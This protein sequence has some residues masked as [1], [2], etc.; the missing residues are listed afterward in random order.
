MHISENGGGWGVGVKG[1][2][3]EGEKK[4]KRVGEGREGGG[5]KGEVI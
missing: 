3:C 4:D 5:G 2:V 1:D